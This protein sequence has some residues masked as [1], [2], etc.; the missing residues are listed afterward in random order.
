MAD[1]GAS[2]IGG[3]GFSGAINVNFEMQMFDEIDTDSLALTFDADPEAFE[4]SGPFLAMTKYTPNRTINEG[5]TIPFTITVHNYGDEA[6][7]NLRVLDGMSSGLDGEREF[8]WERATL[9]ADDT[10]T[11]SYSV[12]ATDSGLYMDMPAFCVYFNTTLDTFNPTS[13][14]DWDGSAR[15]TMTAPGYQILIQGTEPSWLDELISGDIMGIPTLYVV[16]GLSGV[17]IIGVVVMVV[18]RR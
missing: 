15:Y 2:L 14:E 1:L 18:R 5:D 7:Y 8:L 10:W 3:I 9:A 6:A 4:I 17:A 12:D 16:A 13:A 11:I